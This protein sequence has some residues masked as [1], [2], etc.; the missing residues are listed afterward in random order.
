MSLYHLEKSVIQ[1]FFFLSTALVIK[2]IPFTLKNTRT[3][4]KLTVPFLSRITI[5]TFQP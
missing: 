3:K 4:I 2:K 5:L 1:I